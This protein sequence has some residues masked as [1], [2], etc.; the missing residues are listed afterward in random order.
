MLIIGVDV[1]IRVLEERHYCITKGYESKKKVVLDWKRPFDGEDTMGHGI[2]VMVMC[3]WYIIVVQIIPI[4][5][6]LS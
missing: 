4:N 3:L 2:A 1:E 6:S 5:K